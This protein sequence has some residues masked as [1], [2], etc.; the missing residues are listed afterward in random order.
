M[1]CRP[2]TGR[3]LLQLWGLTL[4]PAASLADELIMRDGSRLLGTVVNK[5][6]NVLEFA[7]S[8]AGTVM[9]QWDQ[10]AE[11]RTDRA[12]AVLLDDEKLIEA[13]VIRNEGDVCL[14][15]TGLDSEPVS[16]PASRLAFINPEPWRL[17][18]GFKFTGQVNFA[19]EYERG[20][21][22]TDEIDVDGNLLWRKRHDR[23]RLQGQ[24]EH[25]QSQGRTTSDNWNA[26][27]KYDHFFTRKW[28]VGVVLLAESDDFADLNL[29]IGAGPGIGYQ[30]YES[31][32]LNLSAETGI[33]AVHEE[34]SNTSNNNYGALGWRIDFDRFLFGDA[35]QFYHR[36]TGLWSLKDTS[37]VI[38]D[39]WTGLRFPMVLGLVASTEVNLDYDSGATEGADE[40]DQTYTIKLGYQ[41]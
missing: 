41:W 36:Q 4:L 35:L 32:P 39:T 23:F 38:W 31:K 24:L 21:T 27:G 12:S 22:D 7:T 25:D 16:Y 18:T 26:N 33:I 34:Y 30:F 29:R 11:L 5:T 28:Y 37:D 20:N 13:R 17:G 2:R 19:V 14:V 6:A 9:V 40:W 1:I 15:Q 10:V 3:I 8:F